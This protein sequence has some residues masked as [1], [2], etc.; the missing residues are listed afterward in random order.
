[1]QNLLDIW[2]ST[3]AL[4]EED[5]NH[6][7][8][9]VTEEKLA[10]VKLFMTPHEVKYCASLLPFIFETSANPS[11]SYELSNEQILIS[12]RARCHIHNVMEQVRF[13]SECFF[14]TEAIEFSKLNLNTEDGDAIE[15]AMQTRSR[16]ESEL[17]SVT[18]EVKIEYL[19]LFRSLEHDGWDVNGK[20]VVPVGNKFSVGEQ[21]FDNLE[22]AFNF[23]AN[24]SDEV[25]VVA[26]NHDVISE[27]P[28]SP[29]DAL[30]Q[31]TNL[32]NNKENELDFR[33]AEFLAQH[34]DDQ[35]ALALVAKLNGYKRKGKH[36]N[37]TLNKL[38][39]HVEQHLT[40]QLE[41]KTEEY[42]PDVT[43][44]SNDEIFN[45][46]TSPLKLASSQDLVL[47]NTEFN[48]TTDP[49]DESYAELLFSAL[50][51][52]N[53]T[54]EVSILGKPLDVMLDES[55]EDVERR[56]SILIQNAKG[57]REKVKD[58]CQRVMKSGD[59]ALITKDMEINYPDIVESLYCRFYQKEFNSCEDDACSTKSFSETVQR[60]PL[61]TSSSQV[62][63]RVL[64]DLV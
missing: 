15:K 1:M 11:S 53:E 26:D 52:V 62:S 12:H 54:R 35:F 34:F 8:S 25:S 42:S 50:D 6:I 59:L 38:R 31:Y 4:S 23:A 63:K 36:F 20:A 33:D 41:T 21:A 17:E 45:I 3:S 24:G 40:P 7:K 47:T 19:P 16:F 28:D 30:A 58:I 64:V 32:T 18:P 10:L 9:V 46:D 43:V 61:S 14:D 37:S 2:L 29:Q 44:D 51:E 55:I 22:L 13:L 5:I 49:N 27:V 56:A 39:L 48:L 60:V 57:C